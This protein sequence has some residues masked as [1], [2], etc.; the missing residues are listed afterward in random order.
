MKV[1]DLIRYS[2]YE[3]NDRLGTHGIVLHVLGHIKPSMV[4][5]LWNTKEIEKVFS[6]ELEVINE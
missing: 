3:Y 6:D 1:G 5:V 2:P 4:T